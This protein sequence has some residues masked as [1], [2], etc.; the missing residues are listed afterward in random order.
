[1][2]KKAQAKTCVAIE[3]IV[4]EAEGIMEDFK[5]T[6]ALDAELISS[7]QA[8][9]HYEIAHYGTQPRHFWRFLAGKK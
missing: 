6:A 9:E 1:M 3:G 2:G 8:V 5:G 4:A 7:A